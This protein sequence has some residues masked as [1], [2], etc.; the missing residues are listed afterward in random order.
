MTEKTRR[1]LP[2]LLLL[3]TGLWVSGCAPAFPREITDRVD[4][5]IAF[6]ELLADPGKFNGSWVMLGGVIVSSRNA[7]EGT[8]LEILQKPLESDGR[9]VDTDA[10]EGRF[11]VRTEEYLDSAVYHRGR[12]IT[13]VGEVAG[14]ET[15]PLDETT[16]RYPVLA[17][18]S[19]HLWKPSSGPRFFFGV[20]VF[21]RL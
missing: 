12:L 3:I 11:L 2:A 8:Y 14:E 17:S 7:K 10:T 18:K 15:M 4:R 6:K 21:H 13:I 5:H 1:L 20:G 16:Y 19:M 9:P